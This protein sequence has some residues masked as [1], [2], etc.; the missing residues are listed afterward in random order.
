MLGR[1]EADYVAWLEHGNVEKQAVLWWG[2]G[3]T[4]YGTRMAAAWKGKLRGV[5][6]AWGGCRFRRAGG[7]EMQTAVERH[8]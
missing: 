1:E 4:S 5:T 7:E 3:E 8:L 6:G 2:R